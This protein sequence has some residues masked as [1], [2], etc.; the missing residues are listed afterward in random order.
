MVLTS[1]EKNQVFI[2]AEA[3][4]NHN[5][6]VEIAKRLAYAAKKSGANCVKY[7][8][9]STGELVS[10]TAK[11]APYQREG[12]SQNQYQY[13]LL[14]K[15][16]LSQKSHKELISYFLNMSKISNSQAIFQ[17]KIKDNFFHII[18]DFLMSDEITLYIHQ[19]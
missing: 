7:Q 17:L 16:E 1:L 10:R 12:I 19:C 8:S 5:G 3:G 9:F 2:I 4:V 18:S 13:D 11:L 15:L 6:S 14:K